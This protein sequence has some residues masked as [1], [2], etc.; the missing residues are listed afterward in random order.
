MEKE[1]RG[2][3]G[4]EE[5]EGEREASYTQTRQGPGDLSSK[6]LNCSS[7]RIRS[8]EA[9]N[10]ESIILPHLAAYIYMLKIDQISQNSLVPSQ[11]H[12]NSMIKG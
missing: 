2:G 1:T 4:E 9:R 7:W 11:E 8:I 12:Y 10:A 5:E 6:S 3:E